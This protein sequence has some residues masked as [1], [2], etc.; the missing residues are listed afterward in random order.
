MW[1]R[2]EGSAK[3]CRLL[4]CLALFSAVSLA[5]PWLSALF[6]KLRSRVSSFLLQKIRAISQGV[7][8]RSQGSVPLIGGGH[9][10]QHLI[11]LSILRFDGVLHITQDLGC[12]C[13]PCLHLA[14]S[15]RT[16]FRACPSIQ[17]P[18]GQANVARVLSLQQTIQLVR[19]VMLRP[20]ECLDLLRELLQNRT[21]LPMPIAACVMHFA[22]IAKVLGV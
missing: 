2:G 21:V 18:W 11:E 12:R 1:R 13:K 4:I 22:F 7:H 16:F 10:R 15:L 6:G 19:L 8:Q 9:H 14:L 20:D 5:S 17:G 3:E